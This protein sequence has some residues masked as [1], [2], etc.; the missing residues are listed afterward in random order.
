M[1]KVIEKWNDILNTVKIEHDI[2]DISFDTWMRPLDVYA[3]EGNVLY[4][5]APFEP[6]A[7]GYI[8]KKYYLPLK[9]AIGEITGEEYDIKFVLP[10]VAKSLSIKKPTKKVASLNGSNSNLNPN[11]TF[12][13]FVVG[14]NNRFAQSAAL[15]VAESP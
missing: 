12:E 1:E 10:E 4:I 7:L 6:M 9:V 8:Q 14:G 5:L 13:T 3:V 15:A 2:S 11:Y